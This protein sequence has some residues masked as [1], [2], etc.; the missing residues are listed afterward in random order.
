MGLFTFSLALFY[1]GIAGAAYLWAKENIVLS[2]MS[3]G[4]AMVLLT[5]VAPVQFDGPW[6]SIAWASES[7]VMMALSVRLEVDRLRISSYAI[8]ALMT[9]WILAIETP[10]AFSE[11]ATSELSPYL[12]VYLTALIAGY[13]NS[14]MLRQLVKGLEEWEKEIPAAL[15]TAGN[16][17]LTIAILQ[18]LGG[19]WIPIALSIETIVLMWIGARF[20]LYEQR[21]FALAVAAIAIVRIAFYEIIVDADGYVALLNTRMAA[22]LSVIAA[23]CAATYLL[24]TY[25]EQ[26]LEWEQEAL[27]TVGIV[28]ANLILLVALSAEIIGAVDNGLISVSGQAALNTKSLGLS[29]LWATYGSIGL[30]VGIVMG[31]RTVRVGS[32]L[33]LAIP[34]LKLF[35]VD[36]FALESGYRVAAFLV[37]GVL[38]LVGGYLYQR[39]SETIKSLLYEYEKTDPS[40]QLEV[41]AQA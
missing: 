33:L 27:Q 14:F 37:L 22:Y 17:F 2:L 12:A 40:T 8:F 3:A 20:A 26:L 29:L 31:W 19:V 4:I 13:A 5:L 23:L 7:V 10:V 28:A 35:L 24:R 25:R 18:Q 38:L 9:L 30:V 16:V 36:S 15:F 1:G 39:Y 21:T 11:R 41:D 6:V 34:I 32:L